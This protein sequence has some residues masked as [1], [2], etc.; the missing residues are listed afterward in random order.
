MKILPPG[1]LLALTL[2]TSGLAT[3]AEPPAPIFDKLAA[4]YGATP[5][6]IRQTGSTT[7]KSRGQGVLQR[8]FRAPDN[9]RNE[10]RYSSGTEVRI[11][12]GPHA[13]NQATP[14]NAA[15]RSAVALQAARIALPWNLLALKTTTIDKGIETRADGKTVQL[16][17]FPLEPQLKMIVEIE[18]DSG[19]IVRSLGVMTVGTQ[20][21]EFATRYS[22][23]HSQGGRTFAGREE[24]FAMGQHIGD[25]V[26][27]KVDYPDSLPDSSFEPGLAGQYAQN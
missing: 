16:I 7:S 19:H 20:A 13:W 2:L 12:R 10:I 26:I 8:L 17:E 5:A 6:A 18:T 1:L 27:D 3:A 21:M 4:V 15:Q 25:S 24:Q 22:D 14:A 11:L 23:F 9:F